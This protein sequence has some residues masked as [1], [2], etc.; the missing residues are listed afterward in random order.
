[1]PADDDMASAFTRDDGFG[2]RRLVEDP[3]SGAVEVLD[4]I[5]ALA[6]PAAEEAIRT[7]A[8]RL[9]GLACPLLAPVHRVERRGERLSIV[10]APVD[11][12]PLCELLAAL[13]FGTIT[14][15]SDAVLELAAITVRAVGALHERL[16]TLSHGA[17]NPAHVVFG[18]DGSVVLT[19]AVFGD[20]LQQLERKREDLWRTFSLALPA[21]ATT[22]R[23]DR[24]TD[25]TQLGSIVLAV[26]LRRT[27]LAHEYPRGVP[28]L[29]AVAAAE[30]GAAA[31][32]VPRLRMWLEQALQLTSRALFPSAVE[33]AAVF[34]DVLAS[35]NPQR[36]G[37]G[38]LQAAIRSL[39]GETVAA[40]DTPP[41]PPPPAAA[42]A[43]GAAPAAEFAAT[44]NDQDQNLSGFSLLRTVLPNVRPT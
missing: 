19:D 23:F 17:L 39:L 35:V 28:E 44:S 16:G 26:L 20:A 41:A 27:L 6:T 30:N 13:E 8:A 5:P 33:A 22:P 15:P 32:G 3:A 36:A 12:V 29:V 31:A 14:L 18:R 40:G 24:R 7:R 21:A 9:E 37:G 10:S 25:V 38:A 11:G 4:L 43:D 42:A 1:M 2:T 34:A